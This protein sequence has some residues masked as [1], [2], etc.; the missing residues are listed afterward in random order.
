MN[1]ALVRIVAALMMVAM[2][3]SFA[4]SCEEEEEIM[5]EGYNSMA[6]Q[7]ASRDPYATC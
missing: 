4:V 1:K 7:T 2:L 6:G 3:L 5:P